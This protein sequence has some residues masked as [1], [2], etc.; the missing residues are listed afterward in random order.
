M[1]FESVTYTD[2]GQSC[3]FFKI[4]PLADN[5]FSQMQCEAHAEVAKPT[6]HISSGTFLRAIEWGRDLMTRTHNER[7][8]RRPCPPHL[9]I[10]KSPGRHTIGTCDRSRFSPYPWFVY[11]TLCVSIFSTTAVMVILHT[12]VSH[13]VRRWDNEV[14]W[15]WR[16]Q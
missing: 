13:V 3:L 2:S 8:D 9:A 1:H 5:K 4:F 6:V 7:M 14:C 11:S 10:S 15:L 12:V 16:W